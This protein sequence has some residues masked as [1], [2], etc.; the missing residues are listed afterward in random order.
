MQSQIDDVIQPEG[1][2]PWDGDFA[3]NTSYYAEYDNRGTGSVQTG[4][5]TW[6]GIK[7]INA[8]QASS[9]TVAQFIKEDWIK[10]TAVPYAS[11]LM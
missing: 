9:F 5:V 2:L 7:K 11:G 6:K 1:W 3:L 4:R 8:I 10:P